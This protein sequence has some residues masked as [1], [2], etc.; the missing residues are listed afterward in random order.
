MTLIDGILDIIG[1]NKELVRI[2]KGVDAAKKSVEVWFSKREKKGRI[3]KVHDWS[4]VHAVAKNARVIAE[5]LARVK[6]LNRNETRYIGAMAEAT[7][8]FH[9]ISREATEKTP[10]GPSGAIAVMMHSLLGSDATKHF[11]KK[12]INAISKIVKIHEADIGSLD[13]EFEKEKLPE[14]LKIIAKAVVWADKLFEAS[15]HRV[16]ERRSFFVG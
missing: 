6:G 14:D 15:G 3:S 4:H 1:R 12:E 13:K 2:E 11:T 7:G 8:Y 10:H 9:D 5:E 16:L